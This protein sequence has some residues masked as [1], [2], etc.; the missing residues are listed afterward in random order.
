MHTLSVIGCGGAGVKFLGY[1]GDYPGMQKLS[2][3]D[4]Q[5]DILVDRNDL[6]AYM[7]VDKSILLSKFPWI[8]KIDGENI[9][10]IAGL[11]G[12]LGSSA[13]M[14]LSK[15]LS[16]RRIWGIFTYPFR[17]ESVSRRKMAEKSLKYMEGNLTG[18]F[19]LDNDSLISHFSNLG[20]EVALQIAGV[21]SKHIVLDFHRIILKNLLNFKPAGKLGIGIGFGSGKERVKVAIEDAL[22]SPWMQGNKIAILISGNIE[23]DDA[24]YV[25]RN[26][27]PIFWDVYRT[28]E[29]G[30]DV[31]A[32]VIGGNYIS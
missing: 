16:H 9:V 7:E 31:K 2:I 1:I 27:S 11:G 14:L 12:V 19:L 5:A 23:R 28:E 25:V 15:V 21:V 8:R 17:N 20:I 30:D 26:Y 18:Y 13:C 3:N 32:T 4:S 6:Q 29:Y 10:M 22:N 24:K